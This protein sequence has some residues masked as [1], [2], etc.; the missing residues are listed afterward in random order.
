[1]NRITITLIVS[2]ILACGA[3]SLENK[4]IG[5]TTI[6]ANTDFNNYW[7]QG[8]A[9]IN[10]FELS[11]ARYGEL[12]QGDAIMIFVTEDFL[13]DK[14]VKKESNTSEKS[15]PILKLNYLTKFN[16]GI[17]DYSMMTSIFSPLKSIIPLKM[18]CSS[19][20][21]CGH[22]WL[23][24]NNH[25]GV[26][27]VQGSSYFEKEANQS[28]EMEE[29]KTEDGLW[30]LIR[31]NPDQI[32]EGTFNY[33]PSMQYLRLMH[34]E[35]KAYKTHVTKQQYL[36]KDMPGE[37]LMSLTLNYPDLDR[38]IE[39]IYENKAPF[40][41]SGWK[42]TRKSGFGSQSKTL[43]TVAKRTHQIMEPYWNLNKN[44][45]QIYKDKLGLD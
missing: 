42:E 28:F 8:K 19:Q 39:L 15:I 13:V 7:Y 3:Q 30:N 31:L 16:T 4:N 35:I 9:E 32:N 23:Q 20:E 33:L 22:T 40:Q 5:T 21:W 24:I 26:N 17:Y 12:R 6:S 43:E 29:L 11:Q 2:V 44:V 38:T 27:Y 25:E 36:N 45:D 34:K 10:R 18:T 1:M 41:I 14:L 37:N